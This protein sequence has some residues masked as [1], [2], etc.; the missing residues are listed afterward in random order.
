MVATNRFELTDN[1]IRWTQRIFLIGFF[2]LLAML[3][4]SG[5]AHAQTPPP[6]ET[7]DT[8]GTGLL[9]KITRVVNGTLFKVLGAIVFVVGL[10]YTVRTQK[11][12]PL[13]VGGFLSV[14][15]LGAGPLMT[16][17]TSA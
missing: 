13:V 12:E 16:A 9:A 7:L 17:I 4:L 14:V 8:M 10:L 3:M 2:M 11:F 5:T 15:L 1:Q 6:A